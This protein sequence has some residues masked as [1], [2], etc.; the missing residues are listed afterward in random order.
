MSG[1]LI[2][3][4]YFDTLTT[5]PGLAWMGQTTNHIPPHP[6]VTAAMHAAIDGAEFNAYAPPLGFEALRSAI[7]ADLGVTGAE[8]LVTEGV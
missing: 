8:A 4:R 3:N 5:T 6:T 2:R 7:T 1:A